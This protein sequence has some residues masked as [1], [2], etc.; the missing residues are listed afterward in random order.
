MSEWVNPQPSG[1]VLQLQGGELGE[2]I[3]VGLTLILRHLPVGE[4]SQEGIDG[5]ANGCPATVRKGEDEEGLEG[6]R[7]A[8]RK[9]DM[10]V[11]DGGLTDDLACQFARADGSPVRRR[12]R[13]R[14]V[15]GATFNA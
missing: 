12:H 9:R 3:P 6:T 2:Q 4:E 8:L 7:A 1:V 14:R 15:I 5:V 10:G 11:V 13:R